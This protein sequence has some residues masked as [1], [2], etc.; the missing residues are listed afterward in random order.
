[1]T[2]SRQKIN[3]LVT[4]SRLPA[5]MTVLKKFANVLLMSFLLS[6][7][8]IFP[9]SACQTIS[10]KITT[11]SAKFFGKPYIVHPL[12]EKTLYRF[13]GFDCQTYVETVLA[14]AYAHNFDEFK[15]NMNDIRYAD[16]KPNFYTRNNFPD[17]DW[18]PNNVKKGFVQWSDLNTQTISMKI[19]KRK[20][21]EEQTG[22]PAPDFIRDVTVN[23]P[24]VPLQEL[25]QVVPHIP[26]GAIIFVINPT[27]LLISHMGFAIWKDGTL[28]FREASYIKH[29]VKDVPL[30]KYFQYRAHYEPNLKGITILVPNEKWQ[31]SQ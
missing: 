24:Y 22:K 29:V 2:L 26:N 1:M 25:P 15:K 16:G 9:T 10:Q 17:A 19:D 30:L 11:E 7:I 20:W 28:Y 8:I 31:E 14:L 12:D 21:Y 13:D 4:G 27:F 6:G 5:G 23:L 18:I 3:I